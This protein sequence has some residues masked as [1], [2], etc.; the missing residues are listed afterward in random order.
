MTQKA[1]PVRLFSGDLGNGYCK[2]RSSTQRLSFPSV[3]S[4]EDDTASGFEAMG[5]ASNSDFLIEFEGRRW[6][7]GE[8]VYTHGLMPVKIAHRSRIQTEYYRVLFA[9]SLAVGLQ[10]PAEVHAIVSLPPAAYFDREKQKDVIAGQYEVTFGG[11]T[12]TYH[13]PR[14]S[15]RV[16]PEGFGTAALFCLDQS[17]ALQDSSFFD[18]PVGVLDIGTYTTD[19]VFLDKMKLVRRGTDSLTHALHDIHQTLR[20]YVASQG[21]DID[22]YQADDVLRQGYFLQA[23]RNVSI[24]DKRD[25]WAA[26]LTQTI[27]GHI[28][29]L[30]NGGDLVKNILVCGGGASYIAPILALEFGHVKVLDPTESI[31][32]WEANAEGSWRY[33]LFLDEMARHQMQG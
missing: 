21:V 11:R 28:R 18:I 3:I 12:L 10:Q 17:G 15:L 25:E 23:G 30:W 16:V 20:T 13:V 6:A 8:T 32:P 1:L 31:E 26:N 5:L 2:V 14:D 22:E 27:A 33:S 29:T 24:T 4:V 9:A 19:F 7:I